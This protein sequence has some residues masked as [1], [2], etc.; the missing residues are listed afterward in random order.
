[1][2]RSTDARNEHSCINVRWLQR[3]NLFAILTRVA[4]GNLF[5]KLTFNIYILNLKCLLFLPQYSSDLVTL[6]QILAVTFG[7]SPPV[8][9]NKTPQSSPGYPVQSFMP[10][11]GGAS[12][13]N[14]Y[15]PYPA[16]AGGMPAAYMPYPGGNYGAGS[17][18]PPYPSSAGSGYPH[19]T[20]PGQPSGGPG[21]PMPQGN[22][23]VSSARL[24][25]NYIQMNLLKL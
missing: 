5:L 12:P 4:T 7:E 25:L 11:P 1:M 17:N 2:L 21:Y 6:I 8:Y 13:A 18:F 16:A 9:K 24:Y 15:L 19:P 14:P 23:Y 3:K 22:G 20:P 10:Q